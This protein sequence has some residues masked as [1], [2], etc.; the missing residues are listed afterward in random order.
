MYLDTTV[1]STAAKLVLSPLLRR[2]LNPNVH[3][4]EERVVNTAFKEKKD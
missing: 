1:L 2:F 3:L 4:R